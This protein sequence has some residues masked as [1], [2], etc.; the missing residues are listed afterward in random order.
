M[1]QTAHFLNERVF[2]AV[3]EVDTRKNIKVTFQLEKSQR[4]FSTNVGVAS[5]L[6]VSTREPFTGNKL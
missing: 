6:K 1:W 2:S 4:A 3:H 5:L